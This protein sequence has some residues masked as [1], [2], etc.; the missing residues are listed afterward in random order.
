M[1][2]GH[3]VIDVHGHLSS[4]AQFD[5]LGFNLI[6]GVPNAFA[7]LEMSDELLDT[8]T[9]QHIK[10]LDDRNIDVQLLSA[11]PLSMLHW[12]RP[13][14][15]QHWTRTTNNLIH[16]SCRLYPQRFHGVAGLPQQ[17]DQDTS[18][19]IAELDRCINEL[20]FVGALVNPDPG[21]EGETPKLDADYWYP[22]YR[23]AEELNVP[24]IIHGSAP[25]GDQRIVHGYDRTGDPQM[26]RQF[27]FIVEET[28]ATLVLERGL[29]FQ[30]FPRLKVVVVH[31]GGAP[32]RFV[33]R[34]PR[35]NAVDVS[36]NLFFDTC[37]Y[38][39]WFLTATFKQRGV[40]RMVFGTEAPG[41]G[42]GT[43]NPETGRPSDDLVPVIDHLDF[44]TEQDKR[45]VFYENPKKVF[46]L[47][48]VG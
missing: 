31:C 8:A 45:K 16:Q 39:R 1:H 23:R 17:T 12:E 11:R 21:G 5:V 35:P 30:Q 13:Y 36:G 4:P 32:S 25:R 10:V 28:L 22:L 26:D 42:T 44:L 6:I 34:P 33:P 7:P 47:L 29:V 37:A 43:T 48:N 18:H 14:V 9:K 2:N 24:L 41:A 40:D 19:C 46:A 38:D 3:K 27:Y 15:T 20:G